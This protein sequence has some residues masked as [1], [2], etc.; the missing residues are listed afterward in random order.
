MMVCA[1]SPVGDDL[2]RGRGTEACWYGASQYRDVGTQNNLAD[3]DVGVA[4]LCM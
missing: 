2:Q 4:Q 3:A 1:L